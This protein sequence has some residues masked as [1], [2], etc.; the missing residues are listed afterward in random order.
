MQF[1]IG[2]GILRQGASVLTLAAA[3]T[4]GSTCMA[5]GTTVLFEQPTE[6]GINNNFFV[7][8][9]TKAALPTGKFDLVVFQPNP[10]TSNGYLVPTGWNAA[11]QTGFAPQAPMTAQMGYLS[12]AG[13][14]TAQ[15]EGDTV[16]AYI[17]SQDLPT[18][19]NNQL[20]M[21]AP[22]YIFPSGAAPVPF[23]S[24]T[25]VL[26]GELDLQVPTAV[27][28]VTYVAADLAFLDP[29]GTRISYSVNLF[30]NL[31]PRPVIGTHFDVAEAVYILDAPLSTSTQFL[32]RAPNSSSFTGAPWLGFRHFQ[33][34]IDQAQFIA[35]IKYLAAKFPGKIKYL[36][37]SQYV[38]V[39]MHLNAEFHYSP[40]PAELGWSMRGWKIWVSG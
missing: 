9:V 20:M 17:N 32:T 30:H 23:S 29:S 7:A 6:S 15:M 19:L 11:S 35:A 22:N 39:S 14:S 26:S 25:S 16:G 31:A 4:A 12:A 40:A 5:A 28:K 33:W 24:S 18:N 8:H 1:V 36:D 3:V 38:L 21:F 2:L 34:T 37:P 27:G 10:H 13:M